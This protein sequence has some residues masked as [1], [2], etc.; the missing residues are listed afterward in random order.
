[1]VPIEVI[2]LLVSMVRLDGTHMRWGGAIFLACFSFPSSWVDSEGEEGGVQRPSVITVNAYK[3]NPSLPTS[4][5]ILMNFHQDFLFCGNLKFVSIFMKNKK[6][7]SKAHRI[8]FA[9]LVSS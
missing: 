8:V 3:V 7:V 6:P 1:M 4:I 2:L 5:T 9:G